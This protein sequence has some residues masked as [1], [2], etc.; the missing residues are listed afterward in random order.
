MTPQDKPVALRL[1]EALEDAVQTYPQYSEDEPGGYL[2]EQDQLMALA[3]DELRR[4]HAEIQRL[5]AD[6]ERFHWL[7]RNP[8]WSVSYRIKRDKSGPYKEFRMRE[9]GDYWGQ[10]WPTQEQAIDAAMKEQKT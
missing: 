3:A 1:A 8:T 2:T 6:S 4:Q 7:M 5:R 9:E 10:W